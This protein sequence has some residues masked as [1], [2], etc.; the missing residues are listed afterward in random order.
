[1]PT[2]L[3]RH[4]ATRFLK[5]ATRVW[6]RAWHRVDVLAPCRLPRTGPAILVSNHVSPVDPL[7]LQST[8][9][10]VIVWMMAK[11]YFELPVLRTAFEKLTFI[12]VSRSGRDTA[13]L[14]AA[15]R[16]LDAGKVLGIFPEGRIATNGS[17]GKLQPGVAMIAERSGAGVWPAYLQGTMPK[18]SVLRA[19]LEPQ[20]VTVTHG[21][22]VTSSGN[23]LTSDI[24]SALEALRSS[25]AKHRSPHS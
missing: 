2:A 19:Y 20:E 6:A 14:K 10:R 12:P 7:L 24:F 18:W 9:D 23:E 8:T 3:E 1:M 25:V 16:T 13:A 5:A 17:L 22:Q 21:S 4:L 11:E 15:L